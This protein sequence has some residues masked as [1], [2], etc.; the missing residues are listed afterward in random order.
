MIQVTGTLTTPMGVTLPNEE[1][2]ITTVLSEFSTVGAEGTVITTAGGTYDFT[3]EEGVYL[4]EIRQGDEYT[5]GV[6]VE[7]DEN[8][9]T[10]L[11]LAQLMYLHKYVTP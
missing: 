2:R 8:T 5:E 10:P 6:S 9:T 7:I 4:C 3:L 11:S 1:I